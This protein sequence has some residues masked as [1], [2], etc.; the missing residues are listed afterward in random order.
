MDARFIPLKN[1]WCTNVSAES[2]GKFYL[3]ISN[4]CLC[5][6]GE[7]HIVGSGRGIACSAINWWHEGRLMCGDSS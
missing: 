3:R 7:T 2:S 1:L 4:I 5:V 6:F